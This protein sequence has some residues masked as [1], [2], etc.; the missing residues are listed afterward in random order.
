MSDKASK[1]EGTSNEDSDDQY[2][3]RD[4]QSSETDQL[5]HYVPYKS[6][7]LSVNPDL[8]KFP[9]A[10]VCCHC[11]IY[12]NTLRGMR[13]HLDKC[14]H[15]YR[16]R[17]LCGHCEMTVD[18][19]REMVK[20]LN[21]KVGCLRNRAIRNIKLCLCAHPL[22]QKNPCLNRHTLCK[23]WGK[24]LSRTPSQVKCPG[25]TTPGPLVI[26]CHNVSNDIVPYEKKKFDVGGLCLFLVA[27]P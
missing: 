18:D 1:K 26:R 22:F 25:S 13:M 20:H 23:N 7:S 16:P 19:W 14:H 27:P 9:F 8:R 24:V 21:V 10:I 4:W 17:I 6:K 3:R 11:N 2:W 5:L 12:R 15:R